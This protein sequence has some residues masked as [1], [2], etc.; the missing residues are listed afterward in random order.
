MSLQLYL[1]AQAFNCW[2]ESAPA[3]RRRSFTRQYIP[4]VIRPSIRWTNS[5]KMS[6]WVEGNVVRNLRF[7]IKEEF[8]FIVKKYACKNN[9]YP[10]KIFTLHPNDTLLPFP[11]LPSEPIPWPP[12]YYP[13]IWHKRWIDIV[14]GPKLLLR[15]MLICHCCRYNLNSNQLSHY[16]RFASLCSRA[17]SSL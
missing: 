17:A 2:T 13:S 3:S 11:P 12:I 7:A 8:A 5:I 1:P 9:H 4:V 16:F 14:A 6:A 15:E 10:C